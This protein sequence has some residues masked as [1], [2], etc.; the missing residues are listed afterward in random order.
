MDEQLPLDSKLSGEASMS[1]SRLGVPSD[2]H[3]GFNAHHRPPQQTI[4]ES[5]NILL[6]EGFEQAFHAFVRRVYFFS[7]VS[8]RLGTRTQRQGGGGGGHAS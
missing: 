2:A 8:S 5:Y 7:G 1:I 6:N 3:G 4:R